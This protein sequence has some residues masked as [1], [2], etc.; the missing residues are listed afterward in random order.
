MSGISAKAAPA[1]M[2]RRRTLARALGGDRLALLCLGLIAVLLVL[3]IGAPWFAGADPTAQNMLRTSR[4]PS[5][6][7]WFGTDQFGRDI[8]ARILYGGRVS[9][10][11]GIAAPLLAGSLGTMIGVVAGYAGGILDRLVMRVVDLLMAFPSLLLGVLIA[12]AMGP[13]L[14]NVVVALS[15]AF[16]PRFVRIARASTL[17]VRQEPYIEAARAVGQRHRRIVMRHVL[18]NI[19]GPVLVVAS[20]QVATSIRLE[21]TLSFLGLGTQP[22]SPSWG[23]IIRDGM[24]NMLGSPWPIIAS[25][26][27]ITLAVLAFNLLGDQLSDVF[28]PTR[29]ADR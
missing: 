2:P 9:L 26:V 18:P 29:R 1:P 25:G 23:N 21:A 3:A 16:L 14:R 5:A 24:N 8:F 7:N 19:L 27:S 15:I 17:S 11:V 10:L 13:G 6:A 22:P 28:D 20:L 4:D 12:A